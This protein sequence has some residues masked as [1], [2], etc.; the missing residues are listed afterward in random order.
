MVY[1]FYC[2]SC[3]HGKCNVTINT[4]I[5]KR[6]M[7]WCV[8]QCV[9]K[10]R[11]SL[12]H[13]FEDMSRESWGCRA[14]KLTRQQQRPIRRTK[15]PENQWSFPFKYLQLGN[16]THPMQA[17]VETY[18]STYDSVPLWLPL[19]TTPPSTAARQIVLLYSMHLVRGGKSSLSATSSLVS[20][21]LKDTSKLQNHVAALC[22]NIFLSSKANALFFFFF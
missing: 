11:W 20:V 3:G 13:W 18:D 16:V 9:Y 12:L 21:R 15:E 7:P 19:P 8:V 14:M 10:G 5:N 17:T 1:F 4:E 2:I 22:A 6:S